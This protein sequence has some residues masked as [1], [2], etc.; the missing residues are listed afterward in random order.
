MLPPRTTL[1]LLAAA[2]LLTAEGADQVDGVLVYTGGP[3][4]SIT[5][6]APLPDHNV[7]TVG[8]DAAT[9]HYRITVNGRTAEEPGG[10][11]SINYYGSAG[12][13]DSLTVDG[14]G[15]N[16]AFVFGDHNQVAVTNGGALWPKLLGDYDSVDASGGTA[17]TDVFSG[18]HN[19]YSG[20]VQIGNRYDTCTTTAIPGVFVAGQGFAV[21]LYVVSPRDT[22]NTVSIVTDSATGLDTI[23]ENGT[24]VSLSQQVLSINY[25]GS[26]DGGDSVSAPGG[27]F[28]IYGS[29]N[30]VHL[31]AGAAEVWVWGDDNTISGHQASAFVHGTGET[32]TGCGV[33]TQGPAPVIATVY[34]GSTTGGGGSTSG[35]TSSGG[36]GTSSGGSTGGGGTSASGGSTPGGATSGAARSS[37]GGGHGCGLGAGVGLLAL[38]GAFRRRC[39]DALA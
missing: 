25:F 19:T 10:F 5:I 27:I 3:I 33:Q 14:V 32:I 20:N 23:T 24:S 22:G 15:L 17:Y 35:G 31:G 13:S 36:A 18:T 1:L 26:W 11:Y 30:Q 29:Q 21:S 4:D 34:A 8:K 37:S 16:Y 9:G 6:I 38:M 7:V 39:R 12:G 2:M 28:S